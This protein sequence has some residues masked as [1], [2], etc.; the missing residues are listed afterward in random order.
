MPAT[1]PTTTTVPPATIETALA[2]VTDEGSFIQRLL[3][4]ALN[5]P[6]PGET[7]LSFDQMT[8]DWTVTGR[9]AP[10]IGAKLLEGTFAELNLIGPAQHWGVFIL[11]F[12]DPAVFDADRGM[13]GVL[14]ECLRGLLP[15]RAKD[16]SARSW[17]HEHV[18]FICTHDWTQFRFVHFRDRPDGAAGGPPKLAAFGWHAGSTAVRTVC[19]FNLS[20]LGWPADPSDTAGWVAGWSEAFSVE[21]VTKRFYRE[22]AD[23][24]D[25]LQK[26]VTTL[27]GEDQ[28]MFT[29]TLLNRL[30]FIRFIERKGWLTPPGHAAPSP[31]YLRDLFA[32]GGYRKQ[33]FYAGRLRPLFFLGLG[34]EG[35]QQSPAIGTVPFLNGGLFEPKDGLDDQVL[36][37]PDDAL[38]PLLGPGGLFYRYNF[39]VQESTPLN[40][41]VA[42]DPE[43]LGKVFEELVTGRHESGSYYTPRPI[44]SFMCREA[45]KGYLADA[46]AV[47]EAAVAAF[48]DHHQTDS[49]DIPAAGRLAAAL[50]RCRA[51]DPACGSGAY[52]LGLLH[53]MVDLYTLL[54]SDKL[55]KGDGELNKLKLRIISHSLYGVDLDPFATN[56]AML[57]LWLS[58]SVDS[59]VPLPLPNLDF[60]I[61]TGD[62]LAGPDPS[63]DADSDSTDAMWQMRRWKA[64]R[65]LVGRKAVYLDCHDETK[66]AKRLEIF[67]KQKSLAMDLEAALGPGVIDWRV[68]FAE[69][70]AP[71]PPDATATGQ[72]AF[73]NDLPGAQRALPVPADAP[74]G[75]DIVLANP[76]YVRQEL[77]RPHKPRL[78][79]IYPDVYTGTAD[80]SVYFYGRAVQLLRPGGVMAFISPNKWMRAGYGLKLRGF[81]RRHARPTTI[82]DFGHSPVFPAADT[83]PCVPVL[84]R[85]RHPL[86]ADGVAPDGQTF[87]AC[88]L[89]RDDYDPEMSVGRYVAEHATHIPVALLRDDAWT[90]DDPRIQDLGDRIQKTGVPLAEYCGGPP[91]RGILTGFNE[92]FIVDDVLRSELVREDSSCDQ[93]IKPL[94][95]GR[96]VQRWSSRTSGFY[97]ITIGSSAN[98][99]WPWT[100]QSQPEAVFAQTFPSVAKHLARFKEDLRARQDQ[101]HHWWELRSCDYLATFAK[102]KILWQEIQ[103]HSWFS[104]DTSGSLITNKAFMLP[105][106]DLA[107]LGVLCSPLMWWSLTRTLPHMK[108]EALNPAG[109]LMEKL[110]VTTGDVA[111]S[112]AIRGT[113]KTL[114][115]LA[116][117]MH[118]W[119]AEFTA[120]ACAAGGVA[121][122]DDKV[123]GW[124]SLPPAVFAARVAKLAGRRPPSEAEA[125]AVAAVQSRGRARYAELLSAQLALERTLAERVEDAYGLSPADRQLLRSTRPVRDPLDVLA[126]KLAGVADGL[127]AAGL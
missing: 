8:Y 48:V 21:R 104:V 5:W 71:R 113:V 66:T 30:M 41:E 111:T 119:Q 84:T 103:F 94:L 72:F 105:S 63:R 127:P 16:P 38:A 87:A 15:R 116:D 62:S 59:A 92:A 11:K 60:K 13:T 123:V 1:T 75:F 107:L 33:S 43:M 115:R 121:E 109:F 122:P 50:D 98:V 126:A 44:V 117:A 6:V 22:Y 10:E 2:D 20:H 51:V 14:R 106:N 47:P 108:D 118:E 12:K 26:R 65:E 42:V 102:P 74:G 120:G 112:A 28:K 23:E 114:V 19:E 24:F 110:R 64:A 39:T 69:V 90:L 29:Q 37:L 96:D 36:D 32:A 45:L 101:G 52:L 124:V 7:V 53:E 91:L 61:E 76:P 125:A 86:A 17:G 35:Q 18:L 88:P 93:I 3:A 40:V 73:T 55:K 97:L 58:L 25:R 78:K 31:D 46:A 100:G 4:E 56:I 95:R 85:R 9:R 70:F 82:V 80:L 34:K 57:R 54:Y 99:R 89:P 49:I 67:L 27:A 81:L 68:H 79:E 77:I 83:F